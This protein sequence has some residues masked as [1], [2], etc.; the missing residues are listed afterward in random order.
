[1]V[2]I[3][4]PAA[5]RALVG[6][7]PDE[8][9]ALIPLLFSLCGTAQALAA[10][11]ALE[12]A[13]GVDASPHGD[14]RAL[15]VAAET[16]D[17][18]AWQVLMGWPARLGEC[19]QPQAL[20]TLRHATAAI[21]AALYPARD[22]R[23]VGGGSLRPDR[24]MLD[25]ALS[26]L[27]GP[28]LDAVFA[29][30]APVSPILANLADLDSWAAEG[31]TPAAR[32]MRRALAPDLAGFGA[33]DAA[34]P[35]GPLARQQAHPLVAALLVRHGAGVAAHLAARLVE[36]AAL[37]ARMAELAAGLEPADPGRE[38]G[39]PGHGAGAV[40]TARGRLT[41]WVRLD[42]GRI[43]DYR[44]SAPT[45]WNF[46]ADGPLARGLVGAVADAGLEERAGMLVA[47][48]DPCVASTI[49]IERKD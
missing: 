13:L 34:A 16:L 1:M 31:A 7:T 42:G 2:T 15:L 10:A 18:H 35:T 39:G 21:P 32:L 14:A 36:I 8:A 4:R 28:L 33:V 48:L 17:N 5:A 19:P 38:A 27:S 12:A 40:E 49:V 26:R 30:P 43:A 11:Q 46:A 25:A 37:P 24:A 44:I 9:Q 6:R 23:R 20:A 45:E 29:G 47:A 41:H 3:A 22:G